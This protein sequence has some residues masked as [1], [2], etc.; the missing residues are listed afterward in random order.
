M[1]KYKGLLVKIIRNHVFSDFCKRFNLPWIFN[2][3]AMEEANSQFFAETKD[4]FEPRLN[5]YRA[6][7]NGI[8]K[9]IV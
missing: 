6:M 2:I 1:D 7:T 5:C 8:F 4:G 3:D 9:L